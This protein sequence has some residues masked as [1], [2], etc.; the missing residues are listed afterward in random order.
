MDIHKFKLIPHICDKSPLGIDG[1]KISHFEIDN[2][3][4]NSTIEIS[5]K[6]HNWIFE[7]LPYI[8]IFSGEHANHDLRIVDN[9]GPDYHWWPEHAG[10]TEWKEIVTTIDNELFLPRN[11]IDDL[12]ITEWR[13]AEAYLQSLQVNLYAEL[14]LKEYREK[15]NQLI[16]RDNAE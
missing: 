3:I 10:Y 8:K 14:E 1:V 4:K 15:F 16:E 12:Q 7:L 13:T 2:G 6:D 5:N 11:L 9:S